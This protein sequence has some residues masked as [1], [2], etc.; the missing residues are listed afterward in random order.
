[1]HFFARILRRWYRS[2][3]QNEFGRLLWGQY[4]R[5]LL[6]KLTLWFFGITIGFTLLY[7]ALPVP[8]TPLMIQRCWQQAWEKDREVRLKHDWVPLSE[9]SPHL[10]LAVVCA[11]DQEFLEHEGFDFEAIEKAYMHNKKSK[12]KR[13]ASTIS[14]QTAKNVFLWPS[15]S[16]LRKGFEVYFTFLIETVWSKKR[17][18]AA[19]LNSIEYGDGIY[20]AEAAAR[21]Y[22]GKT[23]KELNR[24]ESAL[25][26]SVLPN[27]LIYKADAPSQHV[28]QRQQWILSQMRMWGGKIDYEDPNTPRKPGK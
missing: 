8:V 1:M 18:M 24:Q 13:G 15:R 20:G 3:P 14:Q 4:F 12:R 25:L 10:Q 19:Y 22:F 2:I 5:R 17:I 16:W 7:A 11:E 9:I 21:Y 26:A 27:P 23:A 6:F 28:K